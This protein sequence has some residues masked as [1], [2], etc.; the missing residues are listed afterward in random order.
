MTHKHRSFRHL[1]LTL[2][3]TGLLSTAHAGRIDE[4]T[5][6]TGIDLLLD[7]ESGN[8]TL[9]EGK[10]SGGYFVVDGVL[11]G[12]RV[13]FSTDDDWTRFGIHA[14]VE[15]HF[16]TDT[17]WIPYVGASL[18]FEYLSLDFMEDT[19]KTS[20]SEN[21]LVLGL[22]GG[23][24]FFITETTALDLGLDLSLASEDVYCGSK[25]KPDN[26]DFT[27]RLGFRFFLF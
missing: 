21:A 10:L 4:G 24:K 20:Q 6:E 16:E 9:F 12:A 13:A 11:A 7:F 3:L 8:G 22:S 15:Q 25:G 5:I 17:P 27:M 14:F 1:L 2:L 23:I 26:V 18:G 19:V